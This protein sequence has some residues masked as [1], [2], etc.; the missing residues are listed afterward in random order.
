MTKQVGLKW[1]GFFEDLEFHHGFDP[2]NPCH[3]WLLHLLFLSMINNEINFFIENW[4]HHRLQIQGETSCSPIDL[5]KLDML[6]CGVQ[7]TPMKPAQ[8]HEQVATLDADEGEVDLETYG[9]DS[10]ALSIHNVRHSLCNNS[11]A[12]PLSSWIGQCGPPSHLNLV[13]VEA[14][15]LVPHDEDQLWARAGHLVEDPCQR[16][17]L[18]NKA[19]VYMKSIN[20]V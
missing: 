1:K 17:Q 8:T 12:E 13:E 4:N 11:I 5:F 9:V 18:W 14:P 3:I 20:R 6:V 2:N 7:G 15:D 16:T 10:E 19:L